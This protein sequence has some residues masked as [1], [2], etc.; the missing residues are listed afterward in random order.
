MQA[1]SVRRIQ[2]FLN[3]QVVCRQANVPRED[4]RTRNILTSNVHLF[5]EQRRGLQKKKN[6]ETW[7]KINPILISSGWSQ[8]KPRC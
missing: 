3:I 6:S 2:Q 7:I 1:N 8:G 4:L 5:K